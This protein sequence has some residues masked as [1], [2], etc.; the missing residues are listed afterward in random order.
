[1][2]NKHLQ[3]YYISSSIFNCGRNCKMWRKIV[4][5]NGVSF[6]SA[7]GSYVIPG[8]DTMIPGAVIRP[9]NAAK[10]TVYV[11]KSSNPSSERLPV[12][13]KSGKNC[14]ATFT[15]RYDSLPQIETWSKSKKLRNANPMD[16]VLNALRALQNNNRIKVP[17]R[18]ELE[19]S[20]HGRAYLEVASAFN[21]IM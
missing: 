18:R 21:T 16:I 14:L 1:M 13:L 2:Y 8:M 3:F 17:S 11:P 12:Q 4:K 5:A 15:V 19:S 20:I 9:R 7:Q 10:L 6:G